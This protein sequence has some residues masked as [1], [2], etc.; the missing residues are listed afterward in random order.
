MKF[1]IF[2]IVVVVILL[3]ILR[4]KKNRKVYSS[5]LSPLSPLSCYNTQEECKTTCK[6]Y[7]CI[8]GRCTQGNTICNADELDNICFL[9]NSK[10]TSNCIRTPFDIIKSG[11]DIKYKIVH[12]ANERQLKAKENETWDKVEV[13]DA[14][15]N[16]V[17]SWKL[18]GNW[19]NYYIVSANQNRQ[20]TCPIEYDDGSCVNVYKNSNAFPYDKFTIEPVDNK[21]GICYLQS[22]NKNGYLGIGCIDP[23]YYCGPNASDTD[24]LHVKVKDS[25]TKWK[26]IPIIH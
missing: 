11:Q 14:S 20:I 9:T 4:S 17:Y 21:E 7:R 18:I 25:K 24:P 10:C 1:I 19:P 8:D 22:H 5:L 12:I 26:I 15:D 13:G 6:G 3:I 16:E 2:L 23:P